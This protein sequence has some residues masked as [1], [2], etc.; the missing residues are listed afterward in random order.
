MGSYSAVRRRIE[1]R[2]MQAPVVE[3]ATV[4]SSRAHAM[5]EER[6][7]NAWGAID[8]IDGQATILC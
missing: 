5:S 4:G 7:G 3:K 2:S 8:L 6:T 1:K